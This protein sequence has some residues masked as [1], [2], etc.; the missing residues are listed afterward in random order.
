VLRW[1]VLRSDDS[2]VDLS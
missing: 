2:G 1:Q